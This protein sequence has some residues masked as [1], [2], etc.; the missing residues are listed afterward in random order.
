MKNE[1][2]IESEIKKDDYYI[3]NTEKDSISKDILYLKVESKI[4]LFEKCVD[5]V[6]KINLER[7]VFIEILDFL[8]LVNKCL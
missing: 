4:N 3:E 8:I 1:E 7:L 6:K 2:K 5:E